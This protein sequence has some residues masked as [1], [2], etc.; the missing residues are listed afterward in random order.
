MNLSELFDSEI[1]ANYPAQFENG[2]L[3]VSCIDEVVG[4]YCVD[5]TFD[6]WQVFSDGIPVFEGDEY[7]CCKMIAANLTEYGI[8]S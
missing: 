8:S 2:V 6:R 1:L 7:E 5:S 3:T 4:C